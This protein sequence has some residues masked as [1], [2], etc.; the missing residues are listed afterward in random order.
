MASV[1]NLKKD[2]DLIMTLVINDCL[3]VLEQNS[4]VSD[5]S[6]LNIINEV[7]IKHRE[8]RIR[9]KHPDGKENP[10]LVKKHYN[11]IVSD[12]LIAADNAL[13]KLSGEVK[14]VAN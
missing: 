7:V 2:I 1:R 3:F 10:K 12:L 6:I 5:E 14:K 11:A 13:E 9:A 8:L 4:K